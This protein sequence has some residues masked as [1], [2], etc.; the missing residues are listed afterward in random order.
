MTDTQRYTLDLVDGRL[1][2][3]QLKDVI[4]YMWLRA[5]HFERIRTYYEGDDYG[6]YHAPVRR[7]VPVPYG[8]S[9][10]NTISGYM[11]KPGFIGYASDN[12]P[13][14]EQ[15]DEVF[16]HNHEE[17]TT[18]QLGKTAS[19]YGVAYELHYM[20]P[21]EEGVMPGFVEV[22]PAEMLAIYSTDI[23]DD[24][25]QAAVRWY[26][27]DKTEYIDIYYADVVEHYWKRKSGPAR[28]VTTTVQDANGKAHE[29]E[30][31]EPHYYG[32][33]PVVEYE[34]NR[35]RRGDFEH[36][37]PMI[38]AYDVLMSDSITEV[39]KLAEAYLVLTNANIRDE[40]IDDMR[41]KRILELM[42]EQSK[43]EFLVKNVDPALLTFIRDWIRDEIH[44]QAQVPDMS[45]ESFGG[46]Q[47]GIAIRYKLNTLENLCAVKEAYFQRGLFNRLLLLDAM[48]NIVY[49]DIGVVRE[50]EITFTRNI[51]M[52]YVEIA[53][54]VAQLR[55]H[56]SLQTLLE[57][58]VP[59]V[60][61]AADELERIEEESDPYR[62]DDPL[63]E[64]EP[65]EDEVE[66]EDAR[67]TES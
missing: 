46:T 28:K 17:L 3:K 20:A 47:S 65:D 8:R 13:Y 9:I 1:T 21:T 19:T 45:D 62:M 12:E 32:R 66:D 40:D 10:I 63:P 25:I 52:N 51:P 48:M 31:I 23:S 6:I 60:T 38:D 61:N 59:F 64:I 15:L 37:I 30:L 35:E 58:V 34:N 29:E 7:A 49:G 16:Y 22:P 43:A 14:K 50:I 5:A 27:I 11:F 18:S 4:S 39:E 36:I 54:I 42:G 55:G 2:D 24:D 67:L 57:Q 41:R 44:K 33:V 53:Q 26:E 56:V